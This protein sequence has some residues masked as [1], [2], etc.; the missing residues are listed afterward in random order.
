MNANLT[1]YVLLFDEDYAVTSWA[2]S[3]CGAV[4]HHFDEVD[5]Y[6][7]P[8]SDIDTEETPVSVLSIP[9]ALEDSLAE[10]FEDMESDAMA[11]AILR[12]VDKNP[13]ITKST[14]KF[15]Y[16]SGDLRVS[17]VKPTSLFVTDDA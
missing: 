15:S 16:K 17:L 5:M 3:A 4:R 10:E 9:P 14:V 13:E 6:C 1:M 2:T 8:S 12:L 7:P 11:Q